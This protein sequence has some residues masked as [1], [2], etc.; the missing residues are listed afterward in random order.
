MWRKTLNKTKLLNLLL[1]CF[2]S[3]MHMQCLQANEPGRPAPINTQKSFTTGG[4]SQLQITA[5]SEQAPGIHRSRNRN[6]D[7][8]FITQQTTSSQ[9]K[10]FL[11][12]PR[13]NTVSNSYIIDKKQQNLRIPAVFPHG[14][15][16]NEEED[17]HINSEAGISSPPPPRFFSPMPYTWYQQ[18]ISSNENREVIIRVPYRIQNR[19]ISVFVRRNINNR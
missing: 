8:I 18:D 11:A 4:R 10:V 16:V 15:F 19:D 14:T 2:S 3:A 13:N 6:T 17:I 5:N 9:V 12:L 7:T 1:V